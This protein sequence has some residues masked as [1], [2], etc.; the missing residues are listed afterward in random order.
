M[1][2][3]SKTENPVRMIFQV[4]RS[5]WVRLVVLYYL[6]LKTKLLATKDIG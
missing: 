4:N 2:E 1:A 6:Q 5:P 3:L